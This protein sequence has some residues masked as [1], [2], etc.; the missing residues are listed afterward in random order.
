MKRKFLIVTLFLF[1]A[2][3]AQAKS[4]PV[5]TVFT[6][7]YN[8]TAVSPLSQAVSDSFQTYLLQTGAF[9][10]VE[11]SQINSVIK[12][13]GF[14]SSG[15]TN[16]SDAIKVGEILNAKYIIVGSVSKLQTL[17]SVSTRLINIE[18][19]KIEKAEQIMAAD[20]TSLLSNM[21]LLA[22]KVAGVNINRS[23]GYIENQANAQGAKGFLYIKCSETELSLTITNMKGA[24]IYEGE[25]PASLEIP[26]GNYNVKAIDKK[27]LYKDYETTL[28]IDNE[29]RLTIQINPEPNFYTLEVLGKGGDL[30]IDGIGRGAIPTTVRVSQDAHTVKIVPHSSNYEIF[31]QKLPLTNETKTKTLSVTFIPISI[32][33]LVTTKPAAEFKFWIDNT[34]MGTTPDKFMLPCGIHTFKF[35]GEIEDPYLK[36]TK[37]VSREFEVELLPEHAKKGKLEFSFDTASTIGSSSSDIN[38]GSSYGGANIQTTSSDNYNFSQVASNEIDTT[39]KGSNIYFDIAF[40]VLSDLE[41]KKN[42]F[43]VDFGIGYHYQLEKNL[44]GMGLGMGVAFN[45]LENSA[46]SST[47][48]SATKILCGIDFSYRYKLF[49]LLSLGLIWTPSF[50]YEKYQ[51]NKIGTQIEPAVFFENELAALISIDYSLFTFYYKVGANFINS[52]SVSQINLLNELGISISVPVN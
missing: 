40:K 30:F 45:A 6:F 15:L 17:Y 3:L 50:A 27:H 43:A 8:G 5:V 10:I 23:S 13:Q 26:F 47:E 1:S 49:D 2:F 4:L 32:K 9:D 38:Y 31:E 24:L 35:E 48:P 18:T 7:L 42:R 19:G 34:Y 46:S 20:E 29:K 25:T 22:V 52:K 14:Q 28:I 16:D 36:T 11:Q 21:Q 39:R 12:Q 33:L 41:E 37:M 44:L 51:A